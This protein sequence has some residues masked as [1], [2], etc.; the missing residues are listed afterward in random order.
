MARKL[1]VSAVALALFGIG[2]G[3]GVAQTSSP[4]F[5][6]IVD[7]PGG[8]TTIECVRGCNLVWVERGINPNAGRMSTFK[9]SCTGG[10][11]SSGRVG[12]WVVR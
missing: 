8:E 12:G 11:C 1:T 10:R 7:A 2:W 6:L 5:E 4:D 3:T 9:F